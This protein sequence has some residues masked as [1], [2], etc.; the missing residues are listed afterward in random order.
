MYLNFLHKNVHSLL[1]GL[2]DIVQATETGLLK[3]VIYLI[4]TGSSPNQKKAKNKQTILQIATE[5]E[6]YDIVKYL[7]EKGAKITPKDETTILHWASN[8]GNLELLQILIEKGADVNATNNT[9]GT[10]LQAAACYGNLDIVKCLIS[11]G[12]NSRGALMCA[13]TNEDR[14][15]THCLGKLILTLL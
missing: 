14:P 11:N 2:T 5:R 7:I 9:G 10:A 15:Q 13:S 1:T 6:H 4:E 3:D 8:N 12:A